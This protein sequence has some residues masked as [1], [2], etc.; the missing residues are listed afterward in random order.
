MTSVA[1]DVA[2]QD[3]NMLLSDLSIGDFEAGQGCFNEIDMKQV[4][5]NDAVVAKSCRIVIEKTLALERTL[6]G[7]SRDLRQEEAADP[8]G[9][10]IVAMAVS[11]GMLPPV[12]GDDKASIRYLEQSDCLLE[13]ALIL[14]F[15]SVDATHAIPSRIQSRGKIP[16]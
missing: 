4:E 15:L 1:L 2:L 5:Q 7:A 16:S 6:F 8:G 9:A 11:R 14:F 12:D 3:L 10:G 13:S